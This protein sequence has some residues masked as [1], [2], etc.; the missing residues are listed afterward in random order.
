LIDICTSLF[1][2]SLVIYLRCLAVQA[3]IYLNME[4]NVLKGAMLT[5]DRQLS[6]VRKCHHVVMVIL[7]V[8]NRQKCRVPINCLLRVV[9]QPC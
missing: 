6:S 4:G 3:L 5:F 1:K 7:I 9:S 8:D 2:L